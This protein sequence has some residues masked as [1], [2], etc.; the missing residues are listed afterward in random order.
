[1]K[2]IKEDDVTDKM[3][4]IG[5]TLPRNRIKKDQYIRFIRINRALPSIMKLTE[6]FQSYTEGDMDCFSSSSSSNSHEVFDDETSKRR[7]I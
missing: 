2:V 3:Y 4:I 5:I 6:D 1:M 7:K